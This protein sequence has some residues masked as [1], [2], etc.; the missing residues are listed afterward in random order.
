MP[1]QG[2]LALQSRAV[3]KIDYEEEG[4]R[5]KKKGKKQ[6]LKAIASLLRHT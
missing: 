1:Y 5:G 6:Q 2:E 3:I 4:K